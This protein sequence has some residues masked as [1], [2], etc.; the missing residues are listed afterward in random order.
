M[1]NTIT[2]AD[3]ARKIQRLNNQPS[4]TAKEEMELRFYYEVV[5]KL[6]EL[7]SDSC[8]T[9]IVPLKDCYSIE[10]AQKWARTLDMHVVK[11]GSGL[12]LSW[13]EGLQL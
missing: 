9:T 6:A 1:A 4:L 7:D 8:N 11:G 13:S 10:E 5:Q 2:V 3:F 12:Y